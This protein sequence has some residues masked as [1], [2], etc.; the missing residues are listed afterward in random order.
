MIK[1]YNYT[2]VGYCKPNNKVSYNGIMQKVLVYDQNGQG[3]IGTGWIV[4][5][6]DGKVFRPTLFD[7]MGVK[8]PEGWYNIV[9]TNEA[10][11]VV[12][13]RSIQ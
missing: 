3:I 4:H 1:L 8:L 12:I 7:I 2:G 5:R 11:L 13:P 6:N 9:T 10:K